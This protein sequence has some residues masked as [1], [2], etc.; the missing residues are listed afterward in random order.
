MTLAASL[1]V[2]HSSLSPFVEK[3]SPE[4]IGPARVPSPRVTP[5]LV[6]YRTDTQQSLADT[7]HGTKK[8]IGSPNAEGL[9]HSA[10]DL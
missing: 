7:L 5:Y 4:K 8:Q 6:Q 2:C 10:A 3:F 9:H 1:G